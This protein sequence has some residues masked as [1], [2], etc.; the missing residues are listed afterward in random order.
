MVAR[1]VLLSVTFAL[2]LLLAGFFSVYFDHGPHGPYAGFE[3]ER[4]ER[5]DVVLSFLDSAAPADSLTFLDENERSHMVDVRD[6][7]NAFKIG[8]VTVILLF[9]LQLFL[10]FCIP[11]S[12]PANARATNNKK[13]SENFVL[14]RKSF[15][16][17][18]VGAG[19]F[20]VLLA[21]ASLVDFAW[22]WN[23]PFHALLF[24]HGNWQFAAD[25]ALIALFPQEFFES[26]ARSVLLA[27]ASFGL[28]ALCVRFL[29]ADAL[30]VSKEHL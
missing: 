4:K 1:T 13:P 6:V 23:G 25:S 18:G 14:L 19:G 26:Y 3:G 17:G 11:V 16:Y 27:I 10:L 30:E 29:T 7:L 21:A 28:V 2:C 12:S 15:L 5:V 9:L 20:A 22:F 24:P 8:F